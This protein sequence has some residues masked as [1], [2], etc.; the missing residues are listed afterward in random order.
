MPTFVSVAV[1]RGLVPSE[2]DDFSAEALAHRRP[3]VS[4]SAK[5][6]FA[7][8]AHVGASGP[9]PTFTC[10]KI[11]ALR[12]RKPTL[13]RFEKFSGDCRS[14]GSC[15][16]HALTGSRRT[17][18]EVRPTYGVFCLPSETCVILITWRGEI[19]SINKSYSGPIVT[20]SSWSFCVLRQY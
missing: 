5:P 11:A 19:S 3:L 18:L 17:N 12:S 15:R 13:V 6:K 9:N 7:D 14:S 1:K 2:G 4:N 8:S 10:R 16:S 20:N